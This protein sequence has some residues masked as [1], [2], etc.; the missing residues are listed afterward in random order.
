MKK[1]LVIFGLFLSMNC[2]QALQ[3][4]VDVSGLTQAQI[5]Q[6][7]ADV[8]SKKASPVKTAVAVREEV[9]AWGEMGANVGKAIIGAAKELGMTANDFASTNLGKFV[10]AVI[11][12]KVAGGVV[13][14][15]FVGGMVVII[16]LT[17]G[18]KL[19]KYNNT[20][21][22]Y[23]YKPVLWGLYNKRVITKEQ[24]SHL[25]NHNAWPHIIMACGFIVGVV[26]MLTF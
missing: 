7:A 21:T 18:W 3:Q 9:N 2:A 4:T 19:M 6:I 17:L 11:I 15:I 1:L 14:H 22:T 26:I 8:E 24:F 12:F 23:D 5:A 25:D 16:S 13:L 10:I 20:E